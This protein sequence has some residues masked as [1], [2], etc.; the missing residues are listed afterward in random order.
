[1]AMLFYESTVKPGASGMIFILFIFHNNVLFLM[2]FFSSEVKEVSHKT[3]GLRSFSI[4]QLLSLK[5]DAFSILKRDSR[6][7]VACRF[8]GDNWLCSNKNCCFLV[9]LK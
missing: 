7:V 8:S 6:Y 4:D 3:N 2:S 1:M 9:I 5:S